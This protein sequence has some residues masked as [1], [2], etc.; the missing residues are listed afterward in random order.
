[1]KPPQTNPAVSEL[2][3][4]ADYTTAFA[5]RA[6]ARIGVA[7]ALTDGPRDVDDLALATGTHAPSL[8]RVLRA[9]VRKGVFA[10][11][12][13]GVFALTPMSD[14]LRDDHPTSMRW[15]FRIHP[16]VEA[17]SEMEHTLRTGES[18]FEHVYGMSYW[19]RLSSDKEAHWQFRQSQRAMSR[20]E[21]EWLSGVYKWGSLSTVVDLGGNDGTF[22]AALLRRF[23][24]MRGTVVDL[25]ETVAAAPDVLEETGVGARCSV[26]AADILRDPL[27]SGAD[28]YLI[29]RVLT[30]F[31]D[32][33]VT[34][35]AVRVAEAMRTDSKL[36]IVEPK[37]DGSSVS[38]DLHIL[39]LAKG[40]VRSP[41][42]Y[43]ELLGPAGLVV[44]R[45][46]DA[47]ALD[48]IE[49]RRS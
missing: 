2:A 14:L 3:E 24:H 40:S 22:L 28:A 42:R 44:T 25:K 46:V 12:S 11:P 34:A 27:P 17:W 10:E 5:I 19:R 15:A 39:V 21:V 37:G 6:I 9:L 16:D 47:G 18:A 32:D 1:M 29:K 13:T 26:V 49:A 33:E 8:L 7:D 30:G 43:G 48:I 41:R 36:L 35:F 20:T 45:I 31:D 4:I 23:P 38:M